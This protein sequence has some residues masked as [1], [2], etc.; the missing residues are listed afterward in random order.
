M[1]I[2]ETSNE[3]SSTLLKHVLTT[4][5]QNLDFIDITDLVL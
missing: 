3:K 1:N 4:V 5:Y 2:S